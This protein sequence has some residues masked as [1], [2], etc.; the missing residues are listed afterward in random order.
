MSV[1]I[2][3]ALSLALTICDT[4][5]ANLSP[6]FVSGVMCWPSALLGVMLSE[7]PTQVCLSTD[8]LNK[9][10]KSAEA[11]AGNLTLQRVGSPGLSD[12]L[13]PFF[14]QLPVL[15]TCL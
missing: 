1:L 13:P 14:H 4:S 2:G 3:Y 11:A 8:V 15:L 7:L 10:R 9:Q 12:L 6:I 5:P